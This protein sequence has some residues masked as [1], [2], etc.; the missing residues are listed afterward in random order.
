MGLDPD[1]PSY[2]DYHFNQ[3][4]AFI[5]DPTDSKDNQRPKPKRSEVRDQL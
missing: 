2:I 4:Q 5:D 3:S 1:D